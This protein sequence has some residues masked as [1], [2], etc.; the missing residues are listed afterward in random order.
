MMVF[1]I[2]RP[3]RSDKPSP[4]RRRVARNLSSSST[5]SLTKIQGMAAESSSASPDEAPGP[6]I[7]AEPD[8]AELNN[9][10]CALADIF[11]QVRPE[12][13][14]E[15]L[16]T[17]SGESRLQVVAEQL[18]RHNARWVNGRWRISSKG[19]S[20]KILNEVFEVEQS[21][22]EADGIAELVPLDETFRSETYKHAVRVTLYHE[23]K[24]LSKS[25]IEGVLA[26]QNY[27]YSLSRP[28]L[29]GLAA[30]SWRS[31]FSA[32]LSKWRKSNQAASDSHF[33]VVWN[34]Q[35]SNGPLAV[36]SLRQTTST[37]LNEELE[38]NVLRPLLDRR[39]QTQELISLELATLLNEQE[40][41]AARAIF[42][43]ECCFS[44]A[45]FETMTTCSTGEHT[46]CFKCV[47]NA[48]S[49]ALYGQSWGLSIDHDRSQVACLAPSTTTCT[50]C[51]PHELTRRAVLQMR[52]G[53]QTWAKLEARL[54]D[55]AMR[56]SGS[57]T[58]NCPFCSYAEVD[59]LYLPP[60]TLHYRINLANPVR[61]LLTL[62]VL[63]FALCFLPWYI[64]L[65]VFFHR[66][67]ARLLFERGVQLLIRKTHLPMR[68]ICRNPSCARSSCRLCRANWRD[69]HTCHE[70]AALSLRTTVEAARTAALKRTCP[71]CGLAFV[72]ESGCNKMVCVCG[73]SMCYVCREGLGRKNSSRQ[74]GENVDN[75]NAV[76]AANLLRF[77]GILGEEDN[78]GEGEGYRHFCQHFRPAG[79][80]CNECEKCDLYRAEDE[81]EIVK[82]AGERAE[83]E[84]WR[85]EGGKSKGVREVMAK[86]GFGQQE[87]SRGRIQDAVDRWV[88]ALIKC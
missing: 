38:I 68:F 70:S 34:R 23:M 83:R 22:D 42:E 5:T 35:S 65:S 80:R 21:H 32:F 44:D 17:F 31:S 67:R 86:G 24:A 87:C 40:A 61:T 37:E 78:D 85:R 49:E 62:M 36:P 71:R 84:W 81:D 1:S 69:P 66:P 73:Y 52:G 13:F 56:S 29:L 88:E 48:V 20:S 16:G 74:R 51:I 82:R 41:E 50:G 58:V 54:A 33:M 59:D 64:L 12:V 76:L 26:E 39:A 4:N 9:G 25:T 8:L 7:D 15:M 10:L 46:I 30:K 3:S 55:D 6:L 45:T 57:V 14:R 53:H 27:S 2:F 28:V 18:L 43:C 75:D 79:G 19:A 63:G 60:Q 11:P 72:K 77:G 47:Q